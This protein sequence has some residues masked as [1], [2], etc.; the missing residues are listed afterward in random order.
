MITRLDGPQWCVVTAFAAGQQC[1]LLLQLKVQLTF[2]GF[3]CG[4]LL[5]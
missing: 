2:T 4:R 5:A 3:R 1:K